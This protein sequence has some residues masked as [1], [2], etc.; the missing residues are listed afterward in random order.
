MTQGPIRSLSSKSFRLL[1]GDRLHTQSLEGQRYAEMV[2]EE[3]LEEF[4]N[5]PVA[6]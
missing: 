6:A 2:L 1:R 5:A 4:L 3:R